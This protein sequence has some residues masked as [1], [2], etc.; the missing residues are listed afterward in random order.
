M[1]KDLK[2]KTLEELQQIIAEYG[3]KK[4]FAEYIFSFI[5]KKNASRISQISTLGKAFREKL[6]SDG[7]FISKVKIARRDTDPDGTIKYL[8][9]FDDALAVEAVLLFDDDRT[10]LCI[11][12]Q[13]GCAL[14]CEFCAT[15]KIEFKRNLTAAEITGQVN[16]VSQDGFNATNIVFMGMGEPLANYDNCLKAVRILNHKAG[17]DIGIRHLTISTCGLVEGIKRLSDENIKPR[18]AV[19]LNAATDAL[20]SKLMPINKKYPLKKLLDA[21]QY[22]QYKTG[23]R[24]TFEYMLIDELNDTDKDAAALAGICRK[25]ICNVNLIEF[26]PHPLCT[27]KPPSGEKIS[28]F[29]EVL[30]RAGIK[31]A[32]RE[33]KGQNIKAA[34]GQLGIDFIKK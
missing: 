1:D 19:S 33:K 28:R 26:N 25:F 31:T 32:V 30:T 11:S 4:Y 22:Y 18:L 16:A 9:E 14:G 2:N 13:V 10:T 24:I 21:L 3:E 12:T 29:A 8:F 7:F 15:G 34:C 23:R 20:R 5:H 17:K 6:I 27:F